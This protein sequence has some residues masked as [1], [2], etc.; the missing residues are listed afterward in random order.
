MR[1]EQQWK[2]GSYSA[3]KGMR[4]EVPFII[5]LHP[6][7]SWGGVMCNR[8][9]SCCSSVSIFLLEHKKFHYFLYHLGTL[10]HV[11]LIICSCSILL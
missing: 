9:V 4:R 3:M 11:N 7:P 1:S 6:L 5:S 10:S 2:G 8:R